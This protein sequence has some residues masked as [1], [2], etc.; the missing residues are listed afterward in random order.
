MTDII[1]AYAPWC[2]HAFRVGST[3]IA[4][5]VRGYR[6]NVY[7]FFPPWEYLDIAR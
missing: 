3:L 4:P 5:A 1:A 6:K 7:Y 2:P